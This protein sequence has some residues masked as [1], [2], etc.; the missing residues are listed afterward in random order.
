MPAKDRRQRSHP[1]GSAHPRGAARPHREAVGRVRLHKYLADNGVASRRQAEELVREG[2][3]LVNDEIVDELPAF[4]DPTQDRV[5][6]DGRLVRPQRLEYFL[7]NKPRGVVCTHRDP[8]GRVRAVDLL[9][10][11]A[12]RCFPVGRLD[13]EST[14]L[15]LMTNDGDLA[16]RVTHPR[17]GLPKRYRVTCKG[18]VPAELPE[19][20][21]K[22]VYLSDGKARADDVTVAHRGHSESILDITLHE[23][24]NRQIRRM[25][26]RL[27]FP[28]KQ[29]K[30]VAI[31]PLTSH[32]L[33][34]G[35]ARRLTREELSTLLRALP[36]APAPLDRTRRK[37]RRTND[38]SRPK[39]GGSSRRSTRREDASVPASKTA[40]TTATKRRLIT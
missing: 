4:V 11:D 35:G 18:R 2:R 14:G 24:R 13:A 29:L 40:R 34:S 3:V 36:E 7:I 39:T 20:M 25:L 6:V 28:V 16:Q 5:V 9:P 23:G 19:Q 33:P 37:R 17:F 30:R 27:G 15:L 38:S 8:E 1:G 31:G 10:P 22:G 26:A 32:K 12:A 21:S